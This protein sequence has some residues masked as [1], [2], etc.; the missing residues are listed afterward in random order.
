MPL[1]KSLAVS[2]TSAGK[3]CP[4]LPRPDGFFVLE[5]DWAELVYS[6]LNGENVL[7]TGPTGVGKTELSRLVAQA[8]GYRFERFNLGGMSEFRTSLIGATHLREGRT[9]FQESRFV[10]A[11]RKPQTLILLDEITRIPPEGANLLFSLL[12]PKQRYLPLDESET[13]EVVQPATAVT[14]VATA[15]QGLEYTGTEPLDRALQDR[16]SSTILLDFPNA[17]QESAILLRTCPGLSR[18]DAERLS[19]IAARQR[20]LAREGEFLSPIS[21]RALLAAGRRRAAGF[22]LQAAFRYGV[23]NSFPAEGGDTSERE[24]LLLLLQKNA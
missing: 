5:D 15:N 17:E 20:E 3:C 10:A 2:L 12:D 16:F 22:P 23:I 18:A 4:R 21:T 9:V 11:L 6:V 7:L 24:R 19:K 8:L 13:S 14:F 1:F